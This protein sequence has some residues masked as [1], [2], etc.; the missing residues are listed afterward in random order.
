MKLRAIPMNGEESS[1]YQHG[2]GKE[3]PWSR[4]FLTQ[5]VLC[6]FL[7][8]AF[9]I[10]QSQIKMP[11]SSAPDLGE[12]SSFEHSTDFYFVSVAGGSRSLESQSR[13]LKQVG[14]ISI[15]L[16]DEQPCNMAISCVIEHGY[17][18]LAYDSLY[19]KGACDCYIPGL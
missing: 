16:I 12:L 7:F 11:V 3:A 1:V 2:S 17:Y 8:A 10:G 14:G 13:L 15:S 4:T 18:L 19:W 6:L 9:N 5:A